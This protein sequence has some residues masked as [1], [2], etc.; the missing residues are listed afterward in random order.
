MWLFFICLVNCNLELFLYI[1]TQ[2]FNVSTTVRNIIKALT[3]IKYIRYSQVHDNAILETMLNNIQ[4]YLVDLL[5]MCRF[6]ATCLR[7]HSI[8]L[9]QYNIQFIIRNLWNF[10]M[11]F[12]SC[13]YLMK[14]VLKTSITDGAVYSHAIYF[15]SRLIALSK[16]NK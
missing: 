4:I 1:H 8:Q 7:F 16:W 3:Y 5:D 15:I 12:I 13:Y 2:L 10:R 11:G 14:C 6:C 9:Q